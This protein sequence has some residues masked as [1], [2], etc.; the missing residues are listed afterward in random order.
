MCSDSFPLPLT[1][2]PNNFKRKDAN[3]SC[4]VWNPNE[5]KYMR[6]QTSPTAL[7]GILSPTLVLIMGA[8]VVLHFFDL[9]RFSLGSGLLFFFRRIDRIPLFPPPLFDLPL[10]DLPFIVFDFLDLV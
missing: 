8:S 10:L 1:G 7:T 2:S 3:D 9:L 4:R 5:N 6:P